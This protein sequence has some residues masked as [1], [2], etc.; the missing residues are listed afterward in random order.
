LGG[1]RDA[2]V[3]GGVAIFCASRNSMLQSVIKAP[4]TRSLGKL[5][6]VH[7]TAAQYLQRAA[8]V[9]FVSFAF[10]LAMLVAFYLR[11]QLGYFVLSSA[12]LV[13]YIF[14]MIGL[15]VQKRNT[16]SIHE[17]GIAFKNFAAAWDEIAAIESD[18]A[19]GLKIVRIGGK[20]V[21]IPRTI[22][23]I[24]AIEQTVR[25]HIH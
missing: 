19:S 21:D 4:Q 20:A 3:P 2:A 15:W 1:I 14:A 25:S 17:N 22:S 5:V 18:P 23:N 6:S 11:Q 16:V 8:I 9:A 10:F 12:F 7:G 24:A 13:V